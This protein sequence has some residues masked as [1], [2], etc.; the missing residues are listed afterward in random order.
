[1]KSTRRYAPMDGRLAPV[2]GQASS[3]MGVIFSG[4]RTKPAAKSFWNVWTRC[5]LVHCQAPWHP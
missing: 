4:L 5:F 1:M 2:R 3:G